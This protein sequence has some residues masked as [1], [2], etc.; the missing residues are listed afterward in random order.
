MRFEGRR[1]VLRRVRL[2]LIYTSLAWQPV[3]KQ[4][5]IKHFARACVAFCRRRTDL[6]QLESKLTSEPK[7]HQSIIYI[8][9]IFK[10]FKPALCD[11]CHQAAIR[12]PSERPGECL[13][14]KGRQRSQRDEQAAKLFAQL[15]CL[16][17]QR[18]NGSSMSRVWVGVIILIL[19]KKTKK[20]CA[21]T[22]MEFN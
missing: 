3:S 21:H 4:T 11:G 6:Q 9:P 5:E 1:R 16:H 2:H 10:I 18:F 12:R 13:A 14:R 20:N 7:K 17:V 19:K 8:K 22:Q 15:L